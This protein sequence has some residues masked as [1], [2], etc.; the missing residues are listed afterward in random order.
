MLTPDEANY[1][2]WL[3][4]Q[5]MREYLEAARQ[6]EP[7]AD[8][9]IVEVLPTQQAGDDPEFAARTDDF[10]QRLRDLA[11]ELSTGESTIV[12]V[13]VAA[14]GFAP[15]RDTKDGTHPDPSGELKIAAAVSDTLDADGEI[16]LL[17]TPMP[18]EAAIRA[19]LPALPGVPS[20]P[21]AAESG[22]SFAGVLAGALE[23][24]NALQARA[25]RLAIDAATGTPTTSEEEPQR[26]AADMLSDEIAALRPDVPVASQVVEGRPAD[27]LTAAAVD[28]D[29]LVL[30]SRG[31][32]GFSGLLL[33]SVSQQCIH[34]APCPVVV[35]PP[36][37]R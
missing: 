7:D 22:S 30:G 29:L 25:D 14:E 19:A 3:I 33:G 9:A 16:S 26:R 13:D 28:A 8:F 2:Q 37:P 34:H 11:A 31:L 18:D 36:A 21:E 4:E 23:N 32:G 35:V 12:T 5:D 6:A 20:V 17:H 10:N 1:L 24:L 15:D 27:A